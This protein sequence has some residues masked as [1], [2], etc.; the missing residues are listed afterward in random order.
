VPGPSGTGIPPSARPD[1]AETALYKAL[2]LARATSAHQQQADV[3]VELANLA[4]DLGKTDLAQRHLREARAI[5]EQLGAPHAV[6]V[7]ER[8]EANERD[9][10]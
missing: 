3:L 8:L 2:D 10:R 5:Y 6:A 4:T 1:D 7:A 9:Q